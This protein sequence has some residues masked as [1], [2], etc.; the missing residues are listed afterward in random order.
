M[1][2]YFFSWRKPAQQSKS[3]DWRDT[4]TDTMSGMCALEGRIE[5]AHES[6]QKLRSIHLICA[7]DRPNVLITF[8]ISRICEDEDIV[9]RT[10]PVR[11]A[12]GEIDRRYACIR[13]TELT[14]PLNRMRWN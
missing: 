3:I 14:D 5:P 4:N 2:P 6:S 12:C 1:T 7:G 13:C 10:T 9:Y 11:H 8:A